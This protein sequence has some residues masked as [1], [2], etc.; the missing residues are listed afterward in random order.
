[1]QALPA[2]NPGARH[3]TWRQR[4]LVTIKAKHRRPFPSACSLNSIEHAKDETL[5]EK[6]TRRPI[7]GEPPGLART[8]ASG[9]QGTKPPSE[10]TQ[11]QHH[12][13]CPLEVLKCQT[14][15]RRYQLPSRAA[16]QLP[17]LSTIIRVSASFT[18]GSRLQGARTLSGWARIASSI[19]RFSDVGHCG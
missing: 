15:V 2:L 18:D 17:E 12:S 16:R 3:Q 11:T 6:R 13:A 14:F 5:T 9:L 4:G 19:R 1:M 7:G 10:S 8:N